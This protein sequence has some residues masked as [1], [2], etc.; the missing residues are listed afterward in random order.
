MQQEQ[1]NERLKKRIEELK[2]AVMNRD[3]AIE[4][5]GSMAE[6]A[7]AL[8][9]VFEAADEAAEQY[10]ENIRRRCREEQEKAYAEIVRAAEQRAE[11]ILWVAEE[12]KKR[13]IAEADAFWHKL[14]RKSGGVGNA[15]DKAEETLEN[16]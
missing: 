15:P 14:N 10:K 16:A 3:L 11:E 12:E 4:Q 5:A 8:N 7:L 9:G 1:Q 13:K 2:E 6:A